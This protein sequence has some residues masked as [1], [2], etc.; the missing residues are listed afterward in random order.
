MTNG[1]RIRPLLS[2]AALC[3]LLLMLGCGGGKGAADNTAEPVEM[4]MAQAAPTPQ[5]IPMPTA[6]PAAEDMTFDENGNI[7]L[8][9][10]YKTRFAPKTYTFDHA[11]TVL[12]YHTHAREAFRTPET[13]SDAALTPAPESRK[14]VASDEQSET[15]VRLG[16]LLAEALTKRGFVVIHDRTDVEDPALST[17]YDRS[18]QVMR[19]HKGVDIY[20]DLHRNAAD[21]NRAKNDVVTINGQRTARMFFVVGTGMRE[22]DAS[23]CL[24]NWEDNYTFALSVGERLRAV[25]PALCKDNRVKQ[26]V[27]NQFMGLCL[28]AEVGHNANLL[29]DAEAAIPYLADALQAVCVFQ[30][31]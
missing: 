29:S 7:W 17:A 30:P 25:D 23:G 2:A 1:K 16:E 18:L 4:V 10:A 9:D 21:V 14:R 12:I 24:P 3:V 11:P 5:P 28:L 27:Y 20:I 31:G 13:K 19:A 15:V 26:G 6:T 22:D 8:S